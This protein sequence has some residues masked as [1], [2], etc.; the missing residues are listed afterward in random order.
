HDH[1][2]FY[3]LTVLLSLL[4]VELFNIVIRSYGIISLKDK[5]VRHPN[6]REIVQV[7]LIIISNRFL[8]DRGSDF[9]RILLVIISSRFVSRADVYSLPAGLARLN[10]DPHKL[11]NQPPAVVRICKTLEVLLR[12][13]F[14][15]FFQF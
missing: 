13:S 10:L 2:A 4:I 9:T 5:N 7:T 12:A 8:A 6:L 3:F 11:I 15:D 14:H 1:N